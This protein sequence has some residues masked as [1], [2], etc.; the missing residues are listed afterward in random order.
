M[1]RAHCM[2]LLQTDG[3]KWAEPVTSTAQLSEWSFQLVREHPE[4][5]PLTCWSHHCTM[6]GH[7][8]VAAIA[9]MVSKKE[10]MSHGVDQEICSLL[11]RG[12]V[13]IVSI[14]RKYGPNLWVSSAQVFGIHYFIVQHSKFATKLRIRST[15]NFSYSFYMVSLWS[16]FIVSYHEIS[17]VATLCWFYSVLHV[18]KLWLY[19]DIIHRKSPRT[20]DS[21]NYC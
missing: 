18:D 15:V 21:S 19:F 16:Q 11:R 9:I 5:A 6:K 4:C 12:L 2:L 13:I 1:N 17:N 10:I 7:V 8:V 20:N 14:T 3:G